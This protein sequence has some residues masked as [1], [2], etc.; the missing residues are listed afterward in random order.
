MGLTLGVLTQLVLRRWA[1]SFPFALAVFLEGV[2]LELMNRRLD[3]VRPLGA[4]SRSINSWGG[5]DPHL[6]LFAFMPVLLFGDA[7][8]VDA[9]L[10]DQKL[11][12]VLL[13]A[14][15]GVLLGAFA[16]AGL[17]MWV[18][19][20][21]WTF[22]YCLLFGSILAATDPVTVGVGTIAAAPRGLGRS[23]AAAPRGDASPETAGLPCAGRVAAAPETAGLRARDA[24]RRDRRPQVAVVALLKDLGAS[25]ALTMVIMGEYRRP[26]RSLASRT[27]RRGI[28]ASRARRRR[29][30]SASRARR[31]RNASTDASR[32]RRRRDASTDVL[33]PRRGGAATHS[34]PQI[35]SKRRHG[36]VALPHPPRQSHP[37][38]TARRRA[39]H[40]RG[41]PPRD[42]RARARLCV[43]H[44][45]DLRLVNSGAQIPRDGHDA[46]ARR[47][48]H[49]CLRVVLRRGAHVPQLRHFGDR[50]RT[51]R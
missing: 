46:P 27:T 25:P 2:I 47:D 14:V 38:E 20:Y 11:P 7:M 30:I 16:T 41:P 50:P 17:A 44:R 35:T 29:G 49:F 48:F 39:R 22:V 43:R 33:R 15:P 10:L 13:L 6:L 21:D 45:H 32:P 36:G 5:I 42:P 8:A 31:R 28:S 37:R 18:F 1:P 12:H 23:M 26:R 4:L 34:R 3:G 24:S 9:H 19:P 40:A 51:A